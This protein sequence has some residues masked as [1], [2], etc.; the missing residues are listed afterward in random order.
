M[1]E[2]LQMPYEEPADGTQTMDDGEGGI[3]VLA[4]SDPPD[5]PDFG[6]ESSESGGDRA[7]WD[8]VDDYDGWSSSPPENKDGTEVTD[9][10]GWTR[11]VSVALVTPNAPGTVT[12]TDQGIKRTIPKNRDSE[13][14]LDTAII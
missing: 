1:I 7:D 12:M 11:A 6:R 13:T 8:D 3:V 9:Y 5:T 2:I 4:P 10:A 14:R